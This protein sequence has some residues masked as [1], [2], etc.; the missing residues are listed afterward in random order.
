MTRE[1][2]GQAKRHLWAF[3]RRA[4]N[5]YFILRPINCYRD[6]NLPVH[7]YLTFPNSWLITR[8]GS[9]YAPA[10]NKKT[11]EDKLEFQIKLCENENTIV[12]RD[13]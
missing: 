4:T 6:A 9:K 5:I 7:I 2:A 13:S 8:D 1:I 11:Q 12:G 3:A 10:A